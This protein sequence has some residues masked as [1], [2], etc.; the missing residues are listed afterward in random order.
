MT[1]N[2][3]PSASA[4]PPAQPASSR[5]AVVVVGA[6]ADRRD[7]LTRAADAAGVAVAWADDGFEAV[8]T[9]RAAVYDAIVLLSESVGDAGLVRA[10]LQRSGRL[11]PIWVAAAGHPEALL[12]DR[13]PARLWTGVLARLGQR[14]D[15]APPRWF[16]GDPDAAGLE[17]AVAI[18]RHRSYLV[19]LG[20]TAV[21]AEPTIRAR[22][23]QIGRWLELARAGADLDEI[24][25]IEE[26]ESAA[27]DAMAVL[28]DPVARTAYLER[29]PLD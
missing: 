12:D 27:D 18:A 15:V 19:L 1:R 7:A 4:R 6:Q 5:G 29:A 11:L 8:V 28:L 22:R 14:D 23:A 9:A 10:G 2:R 3:A 26:I 21:D 13:D 17:Q 24:D 16:D 20:S 25:A